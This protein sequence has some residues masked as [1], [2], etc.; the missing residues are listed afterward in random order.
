MKKFTVIAPLG[1]TFG[2]GSILKLTAKQAK[3]RAAS[4]SAAKKKQKGCFEVVTPVSFKFGEV[5]GLA[6]NVNKA[7]LT[8]LT[9]NESSSPENDEAPKVPDPDVINDDAV[10][11]SE[12]GS[13]TDAP[14]N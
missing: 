11:G 2:P 3:L 12:G 5:I 8:A 4:L 9:S 7:V 13:E 6:E 10:E 14:A 1:A